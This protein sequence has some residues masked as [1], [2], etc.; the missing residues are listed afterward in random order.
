[1]LRQAADEPLPRLRLGRTVAGRPLYTVCVYRLGDTLLDS[2]PPA[3]AA[4]LLCWARGHEIRRVVHTHHHEDH[5]GGDHLLVRHL[6]VEILAPAATAAILARG[7]RV[8]LY[9]RLVWGQPRTTPAVELPEEVTAGGLRLRPVATPGHSHDHI[10]LWEPSRAWLF[11]GDLY[12]ARRIQYLR[13]V[14]NAWLQLESLRRVAALDPEALFCAHAGWVRDAR[15]ALD[16]RIAYWLELAD[17]AAELRE[18]GLGVRQIRRRLLGREGGMTALSGG[19]F[20]KSNLIASLLFDR[21]P[22]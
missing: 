16:G 12:V 14:E 13:R 8:P 3:T 22:R 10:A 9:R 6:G 17:A 1:M 21:P 15:R 20:S 18:R 4:E 2:G 5:V 19:E 11:S 7:Y